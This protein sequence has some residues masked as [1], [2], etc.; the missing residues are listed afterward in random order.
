MNK[1]L[2]IFDDNAGKG[3]IL[4]SDGANIKGTDI[5]LKSLDSGKV[6]F[7]GSN[8]VIISGSE[9]NAIKDFDYDNFVGDVDYLESIPSYDAAFKAASKSFKTPDSVEVPISMDDFSSSVGYTFYTGESGQNSMLTPFK[10]L[11]IDDHSAHT[12]YRH[13]ARRVCLW[14]VGIDG[15]GIEASR[16]F[17]VHNTKWIAPYG[18]WDY[19]DGTGGNNTYPTS[20]S[21][22]LTCLIPFKY[23]TTDADLSTTYRKQYFGRMQT[24]NAI[25]YFFKT[26]DED[27]ILIRQYAD[28]STGLEAVDDV[29]KDKRSSE[30]EVVVK[31]K[32][33]VSASDCREYFNRSVGN[34]DSKINTISLCTAI[35]YLKNDE[36]MYADIRPFTRFNFPNEALI[37][38][39]KGIDITYYLYY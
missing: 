5:I 19:N 30:G 38:Y 29:W 34:N 2:K 21:G 20:N 17:K 3:N 12:L 28:D 24:N 9:F 26:F 18:Y 23:R 15:C 31:L 13:V 10:S 22:D 32:M 33:S 39:S 4:K 6:L 14:C 37:D 25:G 11:S 16:V 27:P 1:Q 35:P 7:R 36:L 8:K